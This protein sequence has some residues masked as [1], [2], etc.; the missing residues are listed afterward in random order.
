MRSKS[1]VI[2]ASNVQNAVAACYSTGGVK[3]NTAGTTKGVEQG[4]LNMG[5]SAEARIQAESTGVTAGVV[6]QPSSWRGPTRVAF[7]CTFV[8]FLL[9]NI[10]T[11]ID[12][13][14]FTDHIAEKYEA[15]WQMTIP[16]VGSH[17]LHLPSPITIFTNGSGD[18]T[19][20]YVKALT[21]LVI[22]VLA[23][24][25]WSIL[26]RRRREYRT[27]HQWFM[28]L[29]R[30]ALGIIMISYGAVKVIKSQFPDPSLGRLL[31][32]YGDSSPMGLL[33][34][35]MGA[36]KSYTIFAGTV[37]C[38][39]GFLLFI[40]RLTTLGALVSMAAMGN[41]FI[42]NMSYDVPV[43]LFSFHLLLMSMVL[44]APDLRRLAD[45][46]LLHKPT[47]LPT[48][49]P[50]LRKKWAARTLLAA[51]VLLVG[52]YSVISFVH[53][54]QALAEY[55]KKLVI[56]GLW[57]VDEFT[58]NG[59]AVALSLDHPDR[60]RQFVMG[61]FDVFVIFIDGNRRRYRSQLDAA[62]NKITLTRR[63][64]PTKK[65]ELTFTN[66]QADQLTLTGK[67][68]GRQLSVKLHRLPPPVFLLNTRGFHWINEFPYNR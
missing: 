7:R 13:F 45:F 12:L 37:E 9:Y 39:G 64:D 14:P 40:P 68:D 47:Q 10:G 56:S 3:P 34:T 65:S 41:V 57:A 4:A 35:F 30:I 48:Y 8:Y 18:T 36:S 42:L 61:P 58:V 67:M 62:A 51:Q 22:A 46:F 25:I 63:D 52:Y 5:A 31:Q 44:A 59:Q 28:L 23:T 1:V 11:F 24:L 29:L 27:L 55:N 15:F 2:V 20:D 16:W 60:W 21:Q 32:P 26:D 17:L 19:Y 33:W 38:L 54:H 53:A 6:E 50:K 43:K 66:T 49:S